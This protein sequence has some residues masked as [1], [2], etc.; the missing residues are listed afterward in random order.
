MAMQFGM[1]SDLASTNG[2]K[3]IVHGASGLGKTVLC[4]T[5]P[6]PLIISN[7][8]GLLSLA[9]ANLER[10]F[11]VNTPGISY[12]IPVIQVQ[13]EDDLL[14]AYRW[15]VGS[16]QAKQ[17]E[18]VALD[19]L[20]ELSESILNN[21]KAKT[22]DPRQAYGEVIT[23]TEVMVRSFR[24]IPDKNIYFATKTEATKDELSGI[25]TWGPSMPGAKLGQKLPYFTDEVFQLTR[26]KDAAGKT[27]LV[28]RTRPDAQNVAK[29]RSGALAEYEPPHLGNI[30][31]KIKGS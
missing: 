7:E 10:I 11:G 27:H 2:I 21:A 28:L 3:M 6:K 5:L 30:I 4:A 23:R 15:V 8:S 29:D 26:L 16:D 31:R 24:D 22:K 1:S 9:K 25:V 19:S 17:F 12:N 18:S 20:S 14:E 13:T